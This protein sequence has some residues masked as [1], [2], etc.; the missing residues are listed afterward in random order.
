MSPR[1]KRVLVNGPDGLSKDVRRR[2]F[3]LVINAL[4]ELPEED[5]QRLDSYWNSFPTTPVIS[6]VTGISSNCSAPRIVAICKD[7]GCAIDVRLAAFTQMNDFVAITLLLHEL[8]H[9]LSWA[10]HDNHSASLAESQ[11]LKSAAIGCA[12]GR[13]TLEDIADER[14]TQWGFNP[15]L[16][17]LWIEQ[18][19]W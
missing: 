19:K 6:F 5:W 7:M 13:R 14:V 12:D 11:A 10:N 2:C 9:S 16:V 18:N 17:R 15:E 8:A 3:R 1:L 4:D